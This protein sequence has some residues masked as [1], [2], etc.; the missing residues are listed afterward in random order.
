MAR[1]LIDKLKELKQGLHIH[2]MDSQDRRILHTAVMDDQDLSSQGRG[3][4]Q[5]R[6]LSLESKKDK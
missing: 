4:K 6:V 1:G 3:E 2:L 5:F